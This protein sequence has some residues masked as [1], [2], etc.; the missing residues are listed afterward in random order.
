MTPATDRRLWA[1]A[2]W[3]AVAHI[4]VMLGG[5]ALESTPMLGSEPSVAGAALV[6]ASMAMTFT[7]GYLEFL[8]FLVFLMAVTLIAHLLRGHTDTSRWVSSS[9]AA[10][11]V[12]YVAVTISSGFAAGAAAMYDGHHGVPLATVTTVNDVRNFAY[13]LSIA[14][15]GLF[16]LCVAFAVRVTGTLPRWV[17]S[18]GF[19][20]G[21][22]C[23]V[24]VPGAGFGLVDDAT[25]VWLLWFIA[26]AV[27]A[28]HRARKA[29]TVRST[30][31]PLA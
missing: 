12:T 21:G 29:T 28:L 3:L 19:V 14:V 23:V 13:F 7:G 2:G 1:V 16:T 10:A 4:V 27:A 6:E 9:I 18:T 15:L 17:S 20:A 24:A 30:P 22:L 11:G 5:F 25:L 31:P 8:S 26:F